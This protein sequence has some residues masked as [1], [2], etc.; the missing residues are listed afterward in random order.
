M[1]NIRTFLRRPRWL[2]RPVAVLIAV[3]VGLGG[4]GGAA[5]ALLGELGAA[6]PAMHHDEGRHHDERFG[7]VGDDRYADDGPGVGVGVGGPGSSSPR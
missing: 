5:G 4:L 3:V 2:S 1:R 6:G 7:R